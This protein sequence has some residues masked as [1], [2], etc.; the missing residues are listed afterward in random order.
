MVVM[1]V[2]MWLWG[3]WGGGDQGDVAMVRASVAV[4]VRDEGAVHTC[5][6]PHCPPLCSPP[7]TC[8]VTLNIMYMSATCL[9]HTLMYILCII[10]VS[11]KL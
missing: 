8:P 1:A 11:S 9:D 5:Y 6:Y 10:N 7:A 3:E 4:A 2:M